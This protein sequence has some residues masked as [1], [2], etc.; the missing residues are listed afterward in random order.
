MF[1]GID[2]EVEICPFTLEPCEDCCEQKV[3]EHRKL[4][5]FTLEICPFN[6]AVDIHRARN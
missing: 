6:T 4:C 5:P 1:S 3:F 2:S